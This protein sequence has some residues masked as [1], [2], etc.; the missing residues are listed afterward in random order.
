VFNFYAARLHVQTAIVEHI[1]QLH[2]VT[3]DAILAPEP[4]IGFCMVPFEGML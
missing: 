3:S 4:L 2:H 1:A